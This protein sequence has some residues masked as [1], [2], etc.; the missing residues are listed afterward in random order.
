MRTTQIFAHNVAV[1]LFFFNISRLILYQ[2]NGDLSY[3]SYSRD[4]VSLPGQPELAEVAL[5]LDIAAK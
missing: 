1:E 2:H 5:D 3:G 4:S